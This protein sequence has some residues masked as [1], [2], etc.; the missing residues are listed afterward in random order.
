MSWAQARRI[1][2]LTTA[3]SSASAGNLLTMAFIQVSGA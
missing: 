2:L 1:K 3:L